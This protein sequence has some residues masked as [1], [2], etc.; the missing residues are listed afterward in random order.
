MIKL[1]LS[2]GHV[3]VFKTLIQIKG[4]LLHQVV[5]CRADSILPKR[6]CPARPTCPVKHEVSLTGMKSFGKFIGVEIQALVEPA[7]EG[8]S[9]GNQCWSACPVGRNYRTGVAK[10]ED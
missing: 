4:S 1:G 3:Q 6:A 7:D 9:R 2:R 5:D 10:Q 8:L